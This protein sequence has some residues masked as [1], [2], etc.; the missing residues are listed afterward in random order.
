MKLYLQPMNFPFS[1]SSLLQL[2]LLLWLIELW[3]TPWAADFKLFADL[4]PLAPYKSITE[5]I[6]IQIQVLH[7]HYYPRQFQSRL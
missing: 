6:V 2:T 7:F 4:A 5:V 1:G 3:W